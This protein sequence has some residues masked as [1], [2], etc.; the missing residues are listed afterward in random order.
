MAG[1]KKKVDVVCYR[2]FKLGIGN[3]SGT[4]NNITLDADAIQICLENKAMVNEVLKNGKR[5]PLDFSNFNK[6]NPMGF[7]IEHDMTDDRGARTY[8]IQN[9]GINGK[10]LTESQIVSNQPPVIMQVG[11]NVGFTVDRPED[12]TVKKEEKKEEVKTIVIPPKKEEEKKE[13]TPVAPVVTSITA[14]PP[15]KEDNNKKSNY[16]GKDSKHHK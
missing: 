10:K 11:N 5:V 14:L 6:K 8:T 3:F 7:D 16:T 2:P 13:E 12:P 4:C 9:I 15:S 1:I